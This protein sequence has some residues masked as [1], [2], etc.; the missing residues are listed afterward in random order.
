M[1]NKKFF[2]KT[3]QYGAN[4]NYLKMIQTFCIEYDLIEEQ[5]T[6]SFY[7]IYKINIKYHNHKDLPGDLQRFVN[8][9]TAYSP[10]E[11]WLYRFV[12]KNGIILKKQETLEV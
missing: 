12:E 1:P 11:Q 10:S 8:C 7:L 3:Y 2:Q 5:Y 6:C 4:L 9:L